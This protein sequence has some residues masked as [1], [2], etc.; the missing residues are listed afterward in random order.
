M[1]RASLFALIAVA[2][3]T[4]IPAS[5]QVPLE[6]RCPPSGA[7][8][9]TSRGWRSESLG[10]D[11][12]DPLTCRYRTTDPAGR[13]ETGG[14]F[15]GVANLAQYQH[16]DARRAI[17]AGMDR[18]FPAE[19]G[20]ATSFSWNGS[21]SGL[22]HVPM[23]EEWKAL[24]YESVSV[25]AG[26]FMT[27]VIERFRDLNG[28]VG[29]ETRWVDVQSRFMVKLDWRSVR[30]HSGEQSISWVA[31]SLTSPA[32]PVAPPRPGVPERPRR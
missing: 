23:R 9:Q 31:T 30:G 12:A 29:T 17:Q 22:N 15:Y 24:R 26:Q 1:I 11:P 27:L 6:F 21:F 16:P 10:A 8:Q 4:A 25:P 20:K 13:E 19:P 2:G 3:T 7:I 28:R 5:A 14:S 32:A 18:F